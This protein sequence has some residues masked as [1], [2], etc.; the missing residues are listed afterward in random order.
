MLV[1][2]V[3]DIG[4]G[5]SKAD[6]ARL[7]H[8]IVQFHPEILQNGGGSGL[9]IWISKKIVDLHGGKLLDL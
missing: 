7:F 5:M 3:S 4:A 6:Q 2:E 9:G 1:I 8:E